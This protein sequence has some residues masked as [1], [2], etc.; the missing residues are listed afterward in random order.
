M[1][2][3]SLKTLDFYL[4]RELGEAGRSEVEAHLSRCPACR[5]ALEERRRL[6]GAFSG[7]PDLPV[8][9]DF[10]AAV[11]NRLPGSRRLAFGRFAAMTSSA[12][13]FLA[14]L[15]GYHLMTGESLTDMMLS[16]GRS[17]LAS[18]SQVVPLLAKVLKLTGLA[19]AWAGSL[20]AALVKGL[21][22]VSAFLAPGARGPALA[23]GLGLSFLILYGMKRIFTLGEKT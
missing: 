16:G 21:G 17:L 11:M 3:P 5:H 15:L 14:L 6:L 13:G 2:C 10:A 7:L 9:G 8:P 23:L 20:V 4:E 22:I 18:A 1:S 19:L 12:I